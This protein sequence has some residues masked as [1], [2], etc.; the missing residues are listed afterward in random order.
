VSQQKTALHKRHN[1]K[2][3]TEENKTFRNSSSVVA[4]AR[5]TLQSVLSVCL[6]VLTLTMNRLTFDL[7]LGLWPKM[8]KWLTV[9]TAPSDYRHTKEDNAVAWSV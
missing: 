2:D 4:T 3:S 6:S 9:K 8:I 7:I 5:K 1:T